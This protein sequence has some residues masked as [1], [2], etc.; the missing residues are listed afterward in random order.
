MVYNLWLLATLL[1]AFS[2]IPC[3]VLSWIAFTQG[4]TGV[5]ILLIIVA[6]LLAKLAV[7]IQ[8]DPNRR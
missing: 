7:F 3:L 4:R 2:A 5:A 8:P 6:F 1:I